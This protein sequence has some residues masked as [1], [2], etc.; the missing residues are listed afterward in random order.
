VTWKRTDG[1]PAAAAVRSAFA[2]VVAASLGEVPTREAIAARARELLDAGHGPLRMFV[3]AGAPRPRAEGAAGLAPAARDRLIH[4][5]A[6]ATRMAILT[7]LGEDA[8]RLAPGEL[9]DDG[10]LVLDVFAAP[11]EPTWLG[12]HRHAPQRQPWPTGRS[13]VEVPP[14][15]P[16][17]AY[18]KME[19]ALLWSRAPLR[20]GDCAIEIGS[21]PGGAS[22]SLLRRGLDVIGV[23]PGEMDPRVLA[24]QDRPRF[25]HV[26]AAIG[27]LKKADLPLD[28]AWLALDVN[29]APPVALRYL[30]RVV[31]PRR[32]RLLGAI[33][34]LKLNDATM[35]ARLPELVARVRELGLGT[36]RVTQLPSNRR[37]VCVVALTERGARRREASRPAS[38]SPTPS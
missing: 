12:L 28:V 21:A 8:R 29:L 5:H 2:S 26:R 22:W 10:D 18:A 35:A 17:R 24:F 31:G 37:E 27:A 14:E 6:L 16:S 34:T 30:E 3:H 33:L 25:T 38:P 23:D 36:P 1:A 15:A 9:A 4:D 11:G 13:P 20:P 7:A 32:D 19:E